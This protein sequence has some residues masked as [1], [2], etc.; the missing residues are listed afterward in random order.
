MRSAINTTLIILTL[1]LAFL[2]SVTSFAASPTL[3]SSSAI[4]CPTGL[5]NT[6]VNWVWSKYGDRPYICANGCKSLPKNVAVCFIDADTCTSDFITDGSTCPDSDGIVS[7]GEYPDIPEPPV[8]DLIPTYT[9]SSPDDASVFTA[10]HLNKI[11]QLT[12]GMETFERKLDNFKSFMESTNNS[13]NNAAILMNGSVRQIDQGF[14]AL[15]SRLINMDNSMDSMADDIHALSNS[16]GSPIDYTQKFD[17]INGNIGGLHGSIYG[18][19]SNIQST[20]RNESNLSN[21]KAESN[22]NAIV[23][24]INNISAGGDNTNVI[25]AINSQT[26]EIKSGLDSLGTGIEKLNDALSIG[27]FTPRNFEGKIDFTQTGLYDDSLIESVINETQDLKEEYDRQMVEFRKLFSLDLSNLESG[28]YKEHSLDFE[29][30]NGQRNNFKSGVL[31]AL[32]DNSGLISAVILFFA[33]VCA[34]RIILD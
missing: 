29:F 33:A 30:A 1:M 7:G 16:V 4:E 31:P 34:I 18:A 10:T 13:V 32:L 6:S 9:G 20:I 3:T 25:N 23:S 21:L 11:N 22:K 2:Y 14:S 5:V 15:G 12:S 17:D 26:G 24:A 28:Q 27:S 8:T 19:A